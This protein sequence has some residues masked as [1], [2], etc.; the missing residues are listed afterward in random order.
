[1][2]TLLLAP[3]ALSALLAVPALHAEAEVGKP[4]PDFTLKAGDGK[5]YDLAASKGKTI[6]LEWTNPQCPFVKKYYQQGDMQ[7]LQKDA[8]AKGVVWYRINSGA[9]GKPGSLSA[10]Q[11]AAYDKKYEVAATAS[12]LDPE[13]KVGRAY[14]AKTT[15]HLFVINPKGNVVYAGAIDSKPST[16]H[17]DIATARHYVTEALEAVA[18]DKP[19]AVPTSK[20]YGCSVKY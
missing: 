3:F 12:L 11:V 18:A 20:P 14:G 9:P 7:K 4:A 15:P 17:A 19:V 13:G 5:T 1:M 10:E 6:V 8:T 2:K 16:D